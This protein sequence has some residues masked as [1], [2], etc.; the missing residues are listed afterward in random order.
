MISSDLK[1]LNKLETTL[2]D[3]SY[4]PKKGKIKI[5]KIYDQLIFKTQDKIYQF[6]E[7][8]ETFYI[9]KIFDPV[10]NIKEKVILK[11]EKTNNKTYWINFT[12]RINDRRVQTFYELDESLDLK[13]LPFNSLAHHYQ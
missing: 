5:F 9:S 1:Q 4:L 2:Y 7:N 13:I 11:I 3:D 10:A 12:E 8:K 6:N